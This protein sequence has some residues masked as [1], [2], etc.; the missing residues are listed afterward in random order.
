MTVTN[1]AGMCS[2]YVLQPAVA[3]MSEILLDVATRTSISNQWKMQKIRRD[4]GERLGVGSLLNLH[5]VL[6]IFILFI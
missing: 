1:Q 6:L 5:T 2:K 3:F 4:S